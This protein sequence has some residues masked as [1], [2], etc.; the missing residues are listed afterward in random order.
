MKIKH[1]RGEFEVSPEF[2]KQNLEPYKMFQ[3]LSHNELEA[4]RWRLLYLSNKRRLDV[5]ERL[6]LDAVTRVI[7]VHRA[8]D[9]FDDVDHTHFG[10]K[11]ADQ[12][13]GNLITK[14]CGCQIHYAVNHHAHIAG[15][16]RELL[17]HRSEA[18]CEDHKHLTDVHEHHKALHD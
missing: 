2:A 4:E 16:H 8:L 13:H 14:D 10:F 3:T 7:N 1:L 5:M 6:R 11:F 18:Y 12:L 15:T 17:P 9:R